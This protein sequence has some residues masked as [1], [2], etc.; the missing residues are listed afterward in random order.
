MGIREMIDDAGEEEVLELVCKENWAGETPLYVAAEY[1]Y[2][3]L[4]RELIQFYDLAGAGIK[5]KN[6]F[7]AVHIA[8]KQ[9]DLEVVKTLMEAHPELSMTVD[10]ANTT[11]LHTAAHKVG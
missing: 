2:Y 8:A 11:A 1:G 9:G 7:D 5:A 3:E 10:I 4:V 6:G